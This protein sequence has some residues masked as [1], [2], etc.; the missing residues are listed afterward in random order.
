MRHTLDFFR[1]YCSVP[2]KCLYFYIFIFKRKE[3][4]QTT[5]MC[6]ESFRNAGLFV[7]WP[8]VNIDGASSEDSKWAF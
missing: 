1:L 2:Q 3:I 5:W 6:A 4:Q 7:P 8:W